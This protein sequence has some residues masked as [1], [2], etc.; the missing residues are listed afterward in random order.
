M[1]KNV[2]LLALL[3]V[4]NALNAEPTQT[5][6]QIGEKYYQIIYLNLLTNQQF[7][8]MK[9]FYSYLKG[10]LAT[11]L[12]C[13]PMLASADVDVSSLGNTITSLDEAD[14]GKTYVLYNS[15]FQGYA[16][17]AADKS[18][19]N[20]WLAGDVIGDS[21]HPCTFDVATLDV[22]DAGSSWMLCKKDG[23]YYLY[24]VGAKKYV[25]T[26]YPCTFVDDAVA[27][28][29]VELGDNNFA[30]KPS[31]EG[32]YSYFCAAPN[33]TNPVATWTSNDDGSAWQLIENPNVEADED[34]CWEYGIAPAPA[35]LA[36]KY[37]ISYETT[38]D[39]PLLKSY[40]GKITVDEDGNVNMTGFPGE[41]A[42]SDIDLLSDEDGETDALSYVGSYN[43]YTNQIK[44]S[45][46]DEDASITDVL[47]AS[48]TLNEAFTVNVSKDETTGLYTLS[49]TTGANYTC[50][51]DDEV[52][53]TF[54]SLTFQQLNSYTMEEEDLVGTWE[55][56]YQ[57]YDEGTGDIVD[58]SSTTTFT[59]VEE[60]V[61]YYATDIFGST[62]KAPITINEDG[63]GFVIS[64][65][66]GDQWDFVSNNP[67]G[68]GNIE[69]SYG[70]DN[71]LVWETSMVYS[72]GATTDEGAV[73]IIF[74]VAT[75]TKYV[76]KYVT[77]YT[78]DDYSTHSGRYPRS[79]QI[80]TD[81]DDQTITLAS[82]TGHKLYWDQTE[83]T[84]VTVSPDSLITLTPE[85][86]GIWMHAYA[87]VDMDNDGVFSYD[88]DETNH[89]ALST[90]DLRVFSFYSFDPTGDTSG[91]N[92]EGELLTG[93]ARSVLTLP[94]FAAPSTPGTYRVRYKIDWNN[95][96]PAGS[97]VANNTMQANGGVIVD[98]MLEVQEPVVANTFTMESSDPASDTTV[99]SL[100]KI[101]I[102]MSG[103][104]GYVDETKSIVVYTNEG[105]QVTTATIDYNANNWSGVD[106]TLAEEITDPGDY[107]VVIPEGTIWNMNWDENMDDLGVSEG[108]RY[109]PEIALVYTVASSAAN[110]FTMESADPADGSTVE[111]LSTITITMS[112]KVGYP[113][114]DTKTIVVKDSEGNQVTTATIAL[115]ENVWEN[116]VVT[117]ADE[118]TEE[119][120]Y[121]VVIPEGTI[122]NNLVDASMED[123]GVSMGATYNPEI[124][125]T[126]TVAEPEVY[127]FE[128]LSADPESGST[129]M[130]PFTST[131]ITM[132]GEENDDHIGGFNK[133]KVITV[134]DAQGNVV[135]TAKLSIPEGESSITNKA[136]VTFAEPITEPGTYTITIPSSM[137][138]NKLYNS[139]MEDYNVSGGALYNV[140]EIVLYYT[141]KAPQA[142]GEPVTSLAEID[143]NKTYVLYNKHFTTYAVYEEAQSSDNVWIGGLN[144][145]VTPDSGHG[146]AVTPAVF[147]STSV[148]C[149]WM[150]FQKD[151][152]WY[153]Y[154]M[155]AE[156]YLV[157]PVFNGSMP[158]TFSTESSAVEI[159]TATNDDGDTGFAFRTPETGD[160]SYMCAC[161]G[162]NPVSIWTST[163]NGSVWEVRENPNVAADAAVIAATVTAIDNVNVENA[164]GSIYTIS[165]IK[166]NVTDPRKLSKGLYIIDGKK[167]I[168]K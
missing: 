81:T 161:L 144:G 40:R 22:T 47:Q 105:K 120:T 133:S 150:I 3:Y 41:F 73:H 118:I 26:G 127:T 123:M 126:Y 56:T 146:L 158:C 100:N 52:D 43:P 80:T 141:V 128:F 124:V 103:E 136:L 18:T 60:N 55:V 139:T 36:G 12:L 76:E 11:L 51:G 39:V 110:T 125:L 91:Y 97:I 48:W 89:C 54:S 113:L 82:D 129:V 107:R 149:S 21:G 130:S 111:S 131:T 1:Q 86:N 137:I 16:V 138:Y 109:N 17:Y 106:V 2:F 35:D 116:V 167:V 23:L 87:Y 164:A 59:I 61:S 74:P 77:N 155:G 162:S 34:I 31:T 90:S 72:E 112:D 108:A 159:I 157:T 58:A 63:S 42:S 37:A 101:E 78:A 122:W 29:F 5:F 92:S 69:V 88:V 102:T 24:N 67:S 168:I 65:T 93:D 45:W 143:P 99:E 156:R 66:Q 145:E 53:V 152:N 38:S 132:N 140:E 57:T 8:F 68:T 28:D 165:G 160:Y 121:T 119:G 70:E 9:V 30:F 147:D 83:T 50:D 75:A 134:T 166:L 14:L 85:Y 98:F 20:V 114:D 19:T 115:D 135:T 154:N 163:D 148:N 71:T 44:F 96:D 62:I 15:H 153:A 4:V 95:I 10:I 7:R 6:V 79:L 33:Q 84:V 13:V 94:A 64:F 49:N 117:L 104:V 32:D 25:T 46:P 151:G 142:L 27:L